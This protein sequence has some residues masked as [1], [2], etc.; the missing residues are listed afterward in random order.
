MTGVESTPSPAGDATGHPSL[1]KNI[2]PPP[3]LPAG[4][5]RSVLTSAQARLLTGDM[6]GV[7]SPPSPA[8]G[9]TGYSTTPSANATRHDPE[10]P[11]LPV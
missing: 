3:S 2:L 8:G 9:A 1:P 4:G 11:E 5:R 10:E 7:E 6:T